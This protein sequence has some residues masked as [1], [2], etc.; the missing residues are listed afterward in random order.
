MKIL[1]ISAECYPAAKAGGLGDV[2]GA[3]PKYLTQAGVET[4]VIIPKYR[5]KWLV[6]QKYNELMRGTVRVGMSY[7]AYSIEECYNS[8]LGFRLY[9]VNAPQLFDRS[10]VY[11]DDNVW[12]FRRN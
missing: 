2:V 9:V 10:G 11:M 3:L 5:T 4:A 7:A 6:N 8:T 1:H 12:L